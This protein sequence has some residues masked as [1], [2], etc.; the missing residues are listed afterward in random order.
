MNDA[1]RSSSNTMMSTMEQRPRAAALLFH[2]RNDFQVDWPLMI[3]GSSAAPSFEGSSS[4][5]DGQRSFSLQESSTR[6]GEAA[7]RSW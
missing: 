6:A 2:L 3:G 7:F 5:S 4:K 1:P